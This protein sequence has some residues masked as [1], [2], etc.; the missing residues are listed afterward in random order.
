M[1]NVAFMRKAKMQLANHW[2]EAAIATLIYLVIVLAAS[3]TYIGELILYGP[4]TFGY[5][6]YLCCLI[7]TKTSKLDL[8]FSGFNRFIETLIAGLLI[9]LAT[10]IG[11]A[12]LIVP[13]II[14]GL[15]FS[16]TFFIMAD[17]Q[18][19]SG[20]DA[21]K[22][23]WAMMTG[24]KWDL[25]CLEFRFIGWIILASITCGIG[26][27]WLYPYIMAATLNF[28]RQLRYGTY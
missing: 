23:S 22:Q 3:C 13:G 7:D 15:G 10:S 12:L 18:N 28:Y 11:C 1:D 24:H 17:D 25:F 26:F 4:L 8:L 21:M 16:M 6:L 9:T 2:G 20:I 5:V 14:L 19:I 27:I